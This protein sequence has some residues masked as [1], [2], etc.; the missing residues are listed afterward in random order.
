MEWL[1]GGGFR[2]GCGWS[3]WRVGVLGGLWVE[4]LEGGSF[5][6]GCGRW[7]KEMEDLG[8]RGDEEWKES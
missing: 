7:V 3:G 8:V 6:R 2:G 5:K 1:E 4:W